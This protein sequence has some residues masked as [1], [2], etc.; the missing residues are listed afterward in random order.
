MIVVKVK[1]LLNFL[2]PNL[3]SLRQ[4]KKNTKYLLTKCKKKYIFLLC[5]LLINIK[6]EQRYEAHRYVVDR[7]E[8]N[9]QIVQ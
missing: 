8:R 1:E 2:V 3:H 4:K 6:T 5:L 7:K 9:V